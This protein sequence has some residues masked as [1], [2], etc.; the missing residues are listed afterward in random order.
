MKT[1]VYYCFVIIAMLAIV[2]CGFNHSSASPTAVP[3]STQDLEFATLVPIS[4]MN[5]KVRLIL[6]PGSD[7]KIGS[8]VNLFVENQ[9][10]EV[11]EFRKDYGVKIFTYS[12]TGWIEVGNGYEYH[13][14]GDV[15][16]LDPR[17]KGLF[18][19]KP[20]P[21]WPNIPN[22]NGP[23]NIRVVVTGNISSSANGEQVGSYID[24][25]LNP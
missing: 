7:L 24:I 23:I 11:L 16:R 20:L 4:E 9:S 19:Q 2:G 14:T 17:G 12:D 21:I 3:I 22:N 25:V 6:E 5:T 18:D 8:S 10:N 13:T 1:Y 15:I